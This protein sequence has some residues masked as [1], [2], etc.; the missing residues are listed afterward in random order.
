MSLFVLLHSAH[1]IV[2]ER[3]GRG[4]GLQS[5]SGSK[6]AL[7]ESEVS[8]TLERRALPL[9]LRVGASSEGFGLP[10]P[11]LNTFA[12]LMENPSGFLPTSGTH[13]A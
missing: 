5:V 9:A 1:T 8:V 6:S 2:H 12:H 4:G 13:R 10:P 3:S 7:L 11:T